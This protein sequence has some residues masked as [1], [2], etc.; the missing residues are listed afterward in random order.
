[1]KTDAYQRAALSLE[2]FRIA[3]G[4][5][6]QD[7]AEESAFVPAPGLK[8]SG[9]TFDLEE[10]ARPDEPLF[11]RAEFETAAQGRYI[12]G[13]GADWYTVTRIDGKVVLDLSGGNVFHP[14]GIDKHMVP[15][16][17]TAGRHVLD[18][19]FVRGSATAILCVCV[20]PESVL[21]EKAPEADFGKI[22]GKVNPLLHNSNSAPDIQSRSIRKYDEELRKMN[23]QM[24]RTHDWALWTAGERIIDTHFVFPLMKLDP[25]DPTNYYFDAT[26]E[27]IRVCQEETGIRIFYRLGTSIEHSE[28]RHFNT[29]IPDDFEKYAEVL[30]GIVRHYTKGWANGFHYDIRY[31]EIW[32]EPD[33]GPK[34]WCGDF[35]SFIPFFVTV[36]KRLK[37]EFPELK[38]GG[39]AMA[40]L[41]PRNIPQ[42]KKLLEACAKAGV[43]PDFLSWHCYTADPDWLIEQANIG[44]KLLDECGFKGTETCINEWH[45]METWAGVHSNVTPEAFQN[46]QRIVHGINSGAFNTAVL[47]GWQYSPLDTAFYYGARWE[48]TW[49]YVTENRQLDKN[50][51]S[52]CLM[53][54]MIRDYTELCAVENYGSVH[55]MAAKSADG[56]SAALLVTDFR[57]LLKSQTVKVRGLETA[58]VESAILLDEASNGKPVSVHW[59]GTEL[60]LDKETEGSAVFMIR[61]R[62]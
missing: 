18:V 39:P 19:R 14:P 22:V 23:F 4:K 33:I 40:G 50:F 30:A 5:A 57:G 38:I 52:L 44:R 25:R 42:K 16:E 59:N 11:F 17:L 9:F 51:Y 6:G 24:S 43:K 37:S 47:S 15:L 28:G 49:G 58:K 8:I 34:M 54:D 7:W 35:D 32:N 27:A 60:R 1:M 53:G 62:L 20:A 48:G 41:S 26:D 45:Y 21:H 12:L 31:W 2:K 46:A 29:L 36:L 13:L 61:F 3:P 56:K 55:L 10:Y